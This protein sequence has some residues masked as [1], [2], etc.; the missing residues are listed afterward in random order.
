MNDFFRNLF[1]TLQRTFRLTE[2][3]GVLIH[4]TK[5][6]FIEIDNK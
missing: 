3:R 4:L 2:S 5:V 6:S 1:V